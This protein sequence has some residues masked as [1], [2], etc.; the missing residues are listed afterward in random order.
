MLR[1]LRDQDA[2]RTSTKLRTLGGE[3][4]IRGKTRDSDVPLLTRQL[5]GDADAIAFK[6]LGK[7]RARKYIRPLLCTNG[8]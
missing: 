2:P 5:R 3:S 4:A 7:D 8:L 1:R 6:A